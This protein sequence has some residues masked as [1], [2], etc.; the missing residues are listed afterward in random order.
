MRKTIKTLNEIM[1]Q[2]TPDGPGPLRWSGWM[3]RSLLDSLQLELP[4]LR[5]QGF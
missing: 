5:G 3:G 2:G 4:T 1:S